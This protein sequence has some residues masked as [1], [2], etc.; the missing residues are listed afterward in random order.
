M[1]GKITILD[2]LIDIIQNKSNNIS[3]EQPISNGSSSELFE[4]QTAPF[5]RTLSSGLKLKKNSLKRSNFRN[6]EAKNEDG[7]EANAIQLHD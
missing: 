1:K 5:P 2:I 3:L 6:E 7:S 4:R